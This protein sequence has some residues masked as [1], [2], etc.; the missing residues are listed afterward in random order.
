MATRRFGSRP[1]KGAR[2]STARGGTH[3][4]RE[5]VREESFVARSERARRPAGKRQD[6]R[7]HKTESADQVYGVPVP[8]G[9]HEAIEAERG[10][11]TKAESL[12]GCMA[13]SMEYGTD[14]SETGPYYPDVAQMARDLVRQSINGLDSLVLQRHLLRNRIKEETELLIAGATFSTPG[15]A[16]ANETGL[17]EYRRFAQSAIPLLAEAS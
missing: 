10:N 2:S 17:R 8:D 3:P 4:Y 1:R 15:R 6:K 9:L 5:S 7:K 11:L 16:D 12:L 13:I 14:D